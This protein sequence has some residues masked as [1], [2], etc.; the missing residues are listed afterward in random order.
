MTDHDHR[1]D[2]AVIAAVLHHMNDDHADDS[3]VI[4]RAFG[5]RRAQSARMVGVDGLAGY[6]VYAIAASDALASPV[7]PAP[8]ASPLPPAE[9]SLRLAWSAAI[10]ERAEIRRE[11]VAL[12]G[13]ACVE[14]GIEPRSPE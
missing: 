8:S 11:I 6:W 3:L 10:T 7:L 2:P 4:A 13:R 12:Y 9:V 5:D 14:L 1:F